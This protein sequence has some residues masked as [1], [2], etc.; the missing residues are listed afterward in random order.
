MTTYTFKI[1]AIEFA[2]DEGD[3]PQELLDKATELVVGKE[4][5]VEDDNE[6]FQAIEEFTGLDVYSFRSSEIVTEEEEQRRWDEKVSRIYDWCERTGEN[7]DHEMGKMLAG[8]D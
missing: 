6:L 8:I 5:T 3:K 7:F 4:F 2:Y 1:E